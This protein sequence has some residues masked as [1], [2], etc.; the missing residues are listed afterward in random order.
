[1]PARGLPRHRCR[2]LIEASFPPSTFPSE[3]AVFRGIDAAAS[4][5]PF[6]RDMLHREIRNVFRGIDAAAS[7][8]QDISADNCAL[9]LWAL[10][11]HRCRGLIEA[12]SSAT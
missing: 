1:M 12:I 2:G 5:K 10:P 3:L 7:L 8:K 9:F 4:L 11:R 6:R